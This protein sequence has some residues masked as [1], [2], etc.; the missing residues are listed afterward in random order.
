LIRLATGQEQERGGESEGPKQAAKVCIHKV[1]FV[2]TGTFNTRPGK[3]ESK[4][5]KFNFQ[6]PTRKSATGHG[7]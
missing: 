2:I 6:N 3:S 1:R 5:P 4:N 7:G